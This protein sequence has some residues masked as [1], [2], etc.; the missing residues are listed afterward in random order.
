MDFESLESDNQDGVAVSKDDA[1]L[2]QLANID[3]FSGT[4]SPTVFIVY[5]HDSLG[6]GDAKA[7]VVHRIV[8]WLSLARCRVLSD[9]T[10]IE[11][12][13]DPSITDTSMSSSIVDSQLRILPHNNRGDSNGYVSVDN[14]IVCGSTVMQRYMQDQYAGPYIESIERVY[15]DGNGDRSGIRDLVNSSMEVGNLHH[16]I[17]EIAFLNIRRSKQGSSHGI[18]PLALSGELP[19]NYLTECLESCDVAIKLEESTLSAQH[20]IYFK[21][22]ARIYT[23]VQEEIGEFRRCYD[24]AAKQLCEAPRTKSQ[25]MQIISARLHVASQTVLKQIRGAIRDSRSGARERTVQEAK[26]LELL[27]DLAPL[28]YSDRKDRN[29][30]REKGTCEWTTNHPRFQSWRNNTAHGLLWISADPGCGKSVLSKYLIDEILPNS[31]T[32]TT[33][34]FFFKD[35]FEDQR[36]AVSALRCMIHQLFIQKPTLATQAILEKFQQDRQTLS[37]LRQLWAIFVQVATCKNAEDVVCILDALDEC[38]EDER[39]VLVD[40]LTDFYKNHSP[41]SS[42]KFLITSRPYHYIEREFN[43]LKSKWPTIH[44]TGENEHEMQ[45]IQDEIRIVI[46]ARAKALKQK[47]KLQDEE[48]AALLEGITRVKNRTYLWA[49]LVF[50]VVQNAI[51]TNCSEIEAIIREL[52]RSVE[53]AYEKILSRNQGRAKD[54]A[55]KVMQIVIAAKRPL[56]LEEMSQ[57]LAIEERPLTP[58]DMATVLPIEK[59]PIT[60]VKLQ[61]EPMEKF[62]GTIRQLCG[63]FVT[64]IDSKIYLMHQTARE[65]LIRK[66]RMN[67]GAKSLSHNSGSWRHSMDLM[68]CNHLLARICISTLLLGIND[69]YSAD[70]WSLH[71]RAAD[72]AEAVQDLLPQARRLCCQYDGDIPAFL[73][74]G[75]TAIARIRDEYDLKDM[76]PLVAASILGLDGVVRVMAKDKQADIMG[77]PCNCAILIDAK[78]PKSRLNPWGAAITAPLYEEATK[79]GSEDIVRLLLEEQGS[80]NV[81][82]GSGRTPLHYAT[83]DGSETLVQSLIEGGAKL[84]VKSRYGSTPLHAA[85]ERGRET[86]VRLLIQAGAIVNVKDHYNITPLHE[87]TRNGSETIVQLLIKGGAKAN[88]GDDLNYTPLHGAAEGGHVSMVRL[89]IEAGA[90]VN[91]VTNQGKTPLDL[92]A[93]CNRSLR[94]TTI[95]VLLNAGA[96]EGTRN[97]TSK[98]GRYKLGTRLAQ[99]SRQLRA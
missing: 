7:K 82:D 73:L 58:Q 61:L 88:V 52:P 26:R 69:K 12:F 38:V 22:L 79:Q 16:V 95:R 44:I 80:P 71:V 3:L 75:L 49:A 56:T 63:L 8:R 60:P 1:I 11:P 20:M 76:K 50:D 10:P 78:A 28:P 35:D 9:K 5:A 77:T 27:H 17:T 67:P 57:A 47:L 39:T 89:L 30:A 18:I 81:R 87:A 74:A 93:M 94:R 91:A 31:A 66:S 13:P 23:H 45:Q 14:V 54:K 86:I 36:T 21:L 53:E 98:K 48:Y 99:F 29:P 59:R 64:I 70:N 34:Y 40:L 2:E 96:Q 62:R 37:S 15:N 51:V 19:G 24:E 68:A 25:A 83:R 90:E 33:C 92:A 43:E 85:A 55:K 46:C 84:D 4:Q 42:L 32:R 6:E 41:S 72:S 65:F 97:R